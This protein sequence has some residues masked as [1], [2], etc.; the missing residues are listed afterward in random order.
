MNK[1]GFTLIE[2]LAVIV[3]LAIIALIA[4]GIIL[5]I[6]A[7]SRENSA[8]RSV[9]GYANAIIG[10]ITTFT[11]RH[12]DIAI[13]ASNVCI[14]GTCTN[15]HYVI[16]VESVKEGNFV[17]PLTE[18]LNLGTPDAPRNITRQPVVYS[19]SAV[20]C[21]QVAYNNGQL[22]LRQCH[23][24]G[25]PTAGNANALYFNFNSAN[26]ATRC[27]LN[28]SNQPNCPAI[29]NPHPATP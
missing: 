8:A 28:A 14:T 19:G 2:L 4:S 18:T 3:I 23:V 27:E 26:G 24:A 13:E 10:S 29:P 25:T 5:G 7:D 16:A 20:T 11:G 6:I 15:T 1:K 9:E 22:A 21:A 17:A 12:A